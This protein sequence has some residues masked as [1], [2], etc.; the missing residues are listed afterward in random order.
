MSQR[1]RPGSELPEDLQKLYSTRFTGQESYRNRVWQILTAEF[2][3]RWIGPTDSILDLGC[4]YGEFINNVA[5]AKKFAMDLNP[6]SRKQLE[7]GIEFFEQDCSLAW[8]LPDDSLDVI[9]TSNF[10]EHLPTKHVLQS[11]LV[12]AF[13]CLKPNGRIIA[14]GPNIRHL[15]GEYWDFFDHYLPLSEKSLAEL[16][17]LS[18]FRIDKSVG[19]FLPYTM[20]LGYQPSPQLL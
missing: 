9:F 7:P 3:S 10:F 20:S 16:L 5:G 17:T 11:T 1:I 4:G 15:N 19:R 13:R 8:P 2:F 14:L 6:S 18:G 12:E